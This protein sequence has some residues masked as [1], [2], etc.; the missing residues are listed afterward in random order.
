MVG[1]SPPPFPDEDNA[2][3]AKAALRKDL[4]ARRGAAPM[5]RHSIRAPARCCSAARPRH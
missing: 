4:R 5:S 2:V 3:A 1:P